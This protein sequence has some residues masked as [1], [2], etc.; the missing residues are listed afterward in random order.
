MANPK[1]DV[2]VSLVESDTIVCIQNTRFNR[3]GRNVGGQLWFDLECLE[4]VKNAV[5]DY[6]VNGKSS[7]KIFA[8]DDLEITFSGNDYAP[9][10]AIYNMRSDS[11]PFGGTRARS[12]TPNTGQSLLD[13]LNNLLN[14]KAP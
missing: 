11:A 7:E 13:Q 8:N 6:L 5:E 3:D 4:W 2:T 1:D 9:H 10:L 14:P 12:M